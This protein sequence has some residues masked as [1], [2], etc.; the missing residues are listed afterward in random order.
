VTLT[1]REQDLLPEDEADV[2][3]DEQF[4]LDVD[5]VA[6]PAFAPQQPDE[7]ATDETPDADQIAEVA[8]EWTDVSGALALGAVPN[9]Q[10][11]D[12]IHAVAGS[13]ALR[14]EVASLLPVADILMSLYQ[15]QSAPAAAPPSAPAPAASEV[16]PKAAPGAERVV[17][18]PPRPAMSMP[19]IA[20]T[21]VVIGALALLATLG[22]LWALALSDRIAT[23]NDEIAA[24][25]RQIGELQQSGNATTFVLSP[26]SDAPAGARGT[27]FYSIA[28]GKVLID[29]SGLAELDPDRVY[30]AWFQRS[31]S[32]TWEPGPIFLVN[33][34]GEAVQ[35]L[36]GEA[37][38]F[39][40]IGVTEEPAPGS[41]EPT[42]SFLMEGLL[43]GSTG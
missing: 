36:A 38:T 40:R 35:R 13:A 4:A 7:P 6:D 24:L 12:V 39:I 3:E 1:D 8:Q 34:S 25:N 21:P 29:V 10:I 19:Q 17:A 5:A 43:A 16:K 26:S 11:A 9:D 23:K 27:V 30:Q 41:T 42:G 31:G 2:D 14:A 15:G 22:I 37:P 20:P 28:D 33:S 32:T 18:R